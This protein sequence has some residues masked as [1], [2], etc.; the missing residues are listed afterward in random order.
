MICHRFRSYPSRFISRCV[1]LNVDHTVLQND[2]V[3]LQINLFTT[4]ITSAGQFYLINFEFL[5]YLTRIFY[6]PS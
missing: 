1:R 2:T 4:K 3:T 5:S 6:K